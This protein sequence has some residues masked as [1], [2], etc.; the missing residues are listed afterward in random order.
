MINTKIYKTVYRLA[1]KLM[2]AADEKDREQFD[3]LYAVLRSVC[4][5]I[6]NTD[7]DHPELWVTVA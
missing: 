5:D 7:T 3:S 6:E 2:D 4:I 1:E